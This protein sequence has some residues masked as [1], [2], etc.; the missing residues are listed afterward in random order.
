MDVVES[1]DEDRLD[2]HAGQAR[3]L[4][5]TRQ[6]ATRGPVLLVVVVGTLVGLAFALAYPPWAGGA[7][8]GTHFARAYEIADG[9]L[10]PSDDGSHIPAS[11]RRDQDRVIRNIR[12]PAPFDGGVVSD[13]MDSRP[14]W[15]DLMVFET[16]ATLAASPIAYAP[17]AIGMAVPVRMGWPG[18]VA[19]WFGRIANLAVY[20]ALAALAVRVAIA[21][22]WTLAIAALFPM[23]L[24]IAASVSPD[25]LTIGGFLLVVAVWTRVWSP[26]SREERERDG[27]GDGGGW[28]ARLGSWLDTPKGLAA[29]VLGSGLVLA[30]TKPPYYGILL[31]F[32]ALLL[33]RARDRRVQAAAAAGVGALLVGLGLL[34][35]RGSYQPPATTMLG[36]IVYQ[37]D[38]Q[39]ERLLSDPFGF[40]GRVW[41]DWIANL[42]ATIQLWVRHVGYW[43]TQIPAWVSWLVVLAMLSS[44]MVLDRHDLLRLRRLARAIFAVATVGMVVA[45]YA[46]SYLY[47]DDSLEGE[48]MGVQIPRYSSPLFAVAVMG[49]APRFLLRAPSRDPLTRRVPTWVPVLAVV[50]V[51]AV[52]IVAA[53]RTWL[54]TGRY[55]RF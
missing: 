34:A 10:V 35:T 40:L 20:L 18:L 27:D 41:S 39:R 51:Q 26:P 44:A 54:W 15:D 1:E 53:L 16:Q 52:V 2:P 9:T 50:A 31:A 25:G 7:D 30:V 37:P 24:G 13:L 14:D 17:S 21:F 45:L 6:R 49:L 29:M 23:N 38:V 47:F 46:S 42:D 28:V 43:Q 32:P 5:S 3:C 12:G 8:E 11:L 48:L 19:L 22:R 33:V 36:E 55:P 4:A